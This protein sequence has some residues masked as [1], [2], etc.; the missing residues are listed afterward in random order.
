MVTEEELETLGRGSPGS[1]FLNFEL[2][3]LP[4]SGA[5]L[6]T[7]VTTE[8][9]STPALV[10][11]ICACLICFIVGLLCLVL[12]WRNH[13]STGKVVRQIKERMPP[14]A[15]IAQATA[16]TARVADPRS[17]GSPPSPPA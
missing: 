14:P 12:A 17:E 16:E 13:V 7:L 15:P 5:S 6:I 10:F 1:I 11:F 2:A 9:P 8:I 3:L 4:L